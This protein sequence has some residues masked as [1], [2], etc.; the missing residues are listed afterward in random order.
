[1]VRLSQLRHRLKQSRLGAF[2][3]LGRARLRRRGPR[4]LRLQKGLDRR[5]VHV[6]LSHAPFY[7][8]SVTT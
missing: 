8:G 5:E 3:L 7:L 6:L 1:M 4:L 2:G